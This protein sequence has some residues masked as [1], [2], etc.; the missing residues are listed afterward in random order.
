MYD[1]LKKE[2]ERT[3]LTLRVLAQTI[4]KTDRALL[5][6][7]ILKAMMA[8]C[9]LHRLHDHVPAILEFIQKVETAPEG[10][11][12]GTSRFRSE[13]RLK[14]T[15]DML[16]YI[17]VHIKDADV[18]LAL[19]QRRY[20]PQMQPY[21][22]NAMIGRIL[23]QDLRTI[24]EDVW[25]I[26]FDYAQSIDPVTFPEIA[27]PEPTHAPSKAIYAPKMPDPDRRA[28]TVADTYHD[29]LSPDLTEQRIFPP[30]HRDMENHTLPTRLKNMRYVVID[31]HIYQRLHDERRRTRVSVRRLIK[32]SAN[33]P[34]SLKVHTADQWLNGR[35]LAAEKGL[36]DWVLDAYALLPDAD[37]K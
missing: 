11:S 12:D 30:N 32:G 21:A 1:D 18:N 24:R 2:L 6:P 16:A 36:L 34:P 9:D 31:D 33:A 28:R 25:N 23:K 15:A 27:H 7:A 14:T 37:K 13:K 35:V 26:L 8:E 17:Q 5:P 29:G 22:L 4:I 19:V 20:F 3:G 10:I